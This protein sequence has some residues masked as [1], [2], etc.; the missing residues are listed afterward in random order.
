MHQRVQQAAFRI[1]TEFPKIK[2]L[3]TLAWIKACLQMKQQTQLQKN[4]KPAIPE[5]R[6]HRKRNHDESGE[7]ARRTAQQT[8]NRRDSTRL[9]KTVAI[10]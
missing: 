7:A 8:F 4:I 3:Q 6:S 10:W 1:V 5:A 9:K 2:L